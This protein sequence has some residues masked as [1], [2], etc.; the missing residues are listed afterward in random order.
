MS[1]VETSDGTINVYSTDDTNLSVDVYGYFADA[2]TSPN[3]LALYPVVPARCWDTR[4]TARSSPTGPISNAKRCGGKT[5]ARP[6]RSSPRSMNG[7][8]R[9]RFE[10][11][12]AASRRGA[13]FYECL[14]RMPPQRRQ[15]GR[16]RRDRSVAERLG[17]VRLL[18]HRVL[19][20][21]V[22]ELAAAPYVAARAS[23]CRRASTDR[24][25]LVGG[26][27]FAVARASR[28]GGA[29]HRRDHRE[30]GHPGHR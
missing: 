3:E 21:V 5:S 10:P 13:S 29:A 15:A 7:A 24:S 1:I 23:T 17:L 19:E 26:S 25:G 12:V 18:D 20:L 4:P 8:S 28:G 30:R 22:D 9:S 16:R 14:V 6:M 27:V 2:N 11:V